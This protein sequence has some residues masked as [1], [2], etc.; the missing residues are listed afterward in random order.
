[1]ARDHLTEPSVSHRVETAVRAAFP[2]SVK[3]RAIARDSG[4]DLVVNGIAIQAKWLGEG[5]LRQV[6]EIL[7]RKRDRPD[8]IVARR[9]SPG[10]REA[11][12]QAGIGWVDETGAA[13]IVLG[14]IVISKSGHAEPARQKSDRWTPAVLAVAEALLCE[15]K[16]TV[17]AMREATKLSSGSCTQSLSVLT[18]LGLL[19]AVAARGRDSAR[20]VV[21]AN[22]LLDAYAAAAVAMPPAPSIRVG[23]TWR[24][25]A[26][27]LGEVGKQWKKAGLDWVATGTAAASVIA[28]YIT[29]V[30]TADVY[31]GAKTIASLHAAADL[32]GLRPIDGGRL[33]LRPFPTVTT[34]LLAEERDGLRV[35]PWPRVYVDLRAAGVRGE[36]AAEHLREF[37][38]GR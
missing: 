20:K 11:L 37:R 9:V 14:S 21:D 19:S 33:T 29:S 6:R 5:G 27:G 35:A 18:R 8:I 32:V 30:T 17:S 1:M 34:R 24:E 4:T 10:A 12:S 28:P 3:V 36:E 38:H 15:R 7:T 13:E 31:I 16:A 23:V 26:A 2:R 25:I 22:Q